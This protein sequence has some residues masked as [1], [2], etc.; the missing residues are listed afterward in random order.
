MKKTRRS[1][2]EKALKHSPQVAWRR[3]D[4]EVILLHLDSSDYFNTNPVGHLVWEKIGAGKTLGDIQRAVCAEFDV[5]P[6]KAARDIEAFVQQL[7][8]RKLLKAA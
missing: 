3:I 8:K 2:S 5:T 6:E 4:D 1:P 7:M